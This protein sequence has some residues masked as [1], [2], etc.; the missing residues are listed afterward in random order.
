M[1]ELVL[2]TKV[3]AT[4]HAQ[5]NYNPGVKRTIVRW[6]HNKK[7]EFQSAIRNNTEFESVSSLLNYI[8][9]NVG[10]A[11]KE[12]VNDLVASFNDLLLNSAKNVI[13]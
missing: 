10:V 13:C 11:I 9:T 8:S 6:Q 12:N 4:Q 2:N 1:L 7:T 5:Y 3:I